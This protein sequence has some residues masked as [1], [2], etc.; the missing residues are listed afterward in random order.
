MASHLSPDFCFDVLNAGFVP[1]GDTAKKK[2]QAIDSKRNLKI[3][4]AEAMIQACGK[5][6]SGKRAFR[7]SSRA[8]IKK[9]GTVAA[10]GFMCSKTVLPA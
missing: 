3:T 7:I 9:P 5:P 6:E 8:A 2:H 10:P 1:V 4:A